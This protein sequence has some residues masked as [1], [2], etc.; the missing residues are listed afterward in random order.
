MRLRFLIAL[1]LFSF[2]VFSFAEAKVFN[3]KEFML[4]NGLKLIVVENNKAPLVAQFLCY[5]AGRIDEPKGK[6]GMA[7]LLEHMMFKGT[8]FSEAVDRLGGSDNAFTT[9]DMTCYHQRVA[10][11]YLEKVMAME[12]DRMRR[13]SFSENDFTEEKKVVIEERIERTDSRPEG[14]FRE[15]S[16]RI[17]YED[18]PYAVPTIGFMDEIK[19]LTSGNIKSFYQMYYIPK[20]AVLVISGD[21]E[22]ENVK[23]MADKY[24]GTIKKRDYHARHPFPDK[25][26]G[27]HKYTQE[28]RMR[29]GNVSRPQL[30]IRFHAPSFF[31]PEVDLK[32]IYAIDVFAESIGGSIIG[33]LYQKLVVD[34]KILVSVSASYSPYSRLSAEFVVSAV[35]SEGYDR[36]KTV[37]RILAILAEDLTAKEIDRVR[38]RMKIDMIYL[39]EKPLSGAEVIAPLAVNGVPLGEVENYIEH[40]YAFSTDELNRYKNELLKYPFVGWLE[41]EN[42]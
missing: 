9:N 26:Y 3:A 25:D 27:V 18:S 37:S 30:T 13:L 1:L 24:Y 14:A 23:K 15:N 20:N 29:H 2:V 5:H 8:G 19:S 28:L 40:L 33:K 32:K 35:P 16:S 17:F 4:D 34:E 10:S 12:S 6:S 31:T 7:H 38:E 21:V 39:A 41:Q 42:D 22:A 36:E 11:R